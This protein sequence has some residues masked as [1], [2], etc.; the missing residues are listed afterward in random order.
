MLS[1]HVEYLLIFFDVCGFNTGASKLVKISPKIKYLIFVAHISLALVLTV[2]KFHLFVIYYSVLNVVEAISESLQYSTALF[3]L[4]LIIFDSICHQASHKLFW[5]TVQQID[6]WF[7][8]QF[9]MNIRNYLLKGVEFFFVTIVAISTRIKMNEMTNVSTEIAYFVLFEICHSRV[10]YYLFCLEVVHFQLER[11]KNE[12]KTMQGALN[13][14]STK[15][16][17]YLIRISETSIFYSF[18]LHRLRWI[19]EYFSLVYEMINFLNETF[20]WSQVAAISF[21]FHLLLT[22]VTWIYIHFTKINQLHQ[23]GEQSSNE[24]SFHIEISNLN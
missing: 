22:E 14:I 20:G 5:E 8:Q 9:H 11:I 1:H 4:W 19:R 6:C 18:E 15:S 2:F 17:A 12:V 10:F 16:E 3:T 23:C 21:C 13:F 7:C 24:F